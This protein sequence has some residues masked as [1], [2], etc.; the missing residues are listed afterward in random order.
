MASWH[1]D[2]QGLVWLLDVRLILSVDWTRGGDNQLKDKRWARSSLEDE[3][4]SDWCG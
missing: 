3:L 1:F 2:I 4:S